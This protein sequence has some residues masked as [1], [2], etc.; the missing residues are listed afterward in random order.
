MT[1]LIFSTIAFGVALYFSI[2]SVIRVIET[3]IKKSN[4]E[5][6]VIYIAVFFWTF[7]YYLTHI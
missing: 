3:I 7:F 1:I 4:N 2:V 6:Y 5:M